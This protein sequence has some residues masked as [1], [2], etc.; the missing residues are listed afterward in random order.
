MDLRCKQIRISEICNIERAV[1]GKRYKAGSCYIKLSA[2]DEFVWQ[3]SKDGEID[4]RY[5]VFEPKKNINTKYLYIA[6]E[7]KFPEF[8]RK[9]RTTINL[10]YDTLKYF[11]VDWHD[12]E[13]VQEYVVDAIGTVQKEIDMMEQQ[14]LCERE[15][16]K[17]YLRKM[18]I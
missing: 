2:V 7:R 4:S 12:N 16:K 18:M 6:I 13:K 17:W 10:Q 3:I 1:T 8:L 15:I 5:A 11:S 14:V 9:Y